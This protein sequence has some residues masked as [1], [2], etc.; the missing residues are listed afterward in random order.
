[1]GTLRACWRLVL[2]VILTLIL[3]PLQLIYVCGKKLT[4]KGF[5]VQSPVVRLWYKGVTAILN[6]KTDI[7]GSVRHLSARQSLYVCNHS[8]YLDIII[9]GAY[10]PPFFIAKADTADWPVFG[11]LIKI[12]GTLFI[13]RKRSALLQ[14]LSLIRSA[15]KQ[16][17]SLLL[18]PEG[19]TSDG[20]KTLPFKSSLLNVLYDDMPAMTVT[21]V[22]L[23]Y[24]AVNKQSFSKANNDLIAWYADMDFTP[25]LWDV[26]KLKSIQAHID[27]LPVTLSHEFSDAKALTA[28][29]QNQIVTC[30]KQALPA[31]DDKHP[32]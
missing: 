22:C 26:F 17:K 15:L 1:M 4:A 16:G 20:L 2:F 23:I 5:V 24:Q 25:H 13:S 11:G 27:I 14:Q 6:I 31:T 29:L 12:G 9:L 28:H 8:S 3:V 19:T 10:F 32:G 7:K 21:P 18:F 30:F